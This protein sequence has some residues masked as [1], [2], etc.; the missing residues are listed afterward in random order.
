MKIAKS[1]RWQL[2]L[3]YGVLLVGVLA[4]LG[5]T[6]YKLDSGKQ[7]RQTDDKLHRYF[8]MVTQGLRQHGPPPMGGGPPFGGPP[9]D[10]FGPDGPPPSE[11]DRPEGG[12]RK[13]VIPWRV[14]ELF[15]TNQNSEGVFLMIRG[16]DG[17][18]V[19]Q[20]G[21]LPEHLDWPKLPPPALEDRPIPGAGLRTPALNMAGIYRILSDRLPTGERVLVGCSILT[22]TKE[23]QH[24]AVI[25]FL[26]G[27]AILSFGLFGGWWMVSRAIRPIAEISETAV[28][29]S[30]GD[31]SQRINVAE[32][33]S[34]LGQ[35]AA[36]LNATFERLQTVFAQQQQFTADAAHELR[37]PIAVIITQTQTA[38][39]R[40]RAAADYKATVEA[41]QRAAQRMRRL[42]E[43][44]LELARFDAGQET[45][46]RIP[47]D[48]APCI[49]ESA[50]LVAPLAG[51]RNIK[52]LPE[53]TSAQITG[54]PERIEQVLIN[55]LT[56]A[57]QYNEPGGE[58]QVTLR[59][60][61]SLAVL[62][63]TNTGPGIAPEDLAR[64]SERFYRADKS[65]SV[66]GS[67]LGLAICRAIISAHSG[68]LDIRS[69][70]G[71]GTTV[72]VRLP[73]RL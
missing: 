61:N 55:L 14:A 13:M 32:T 4:G 10:G 17:Q 43:S 62:G 41:C 73:L 68:T 36:V 72:F 47:F 30:G 21:A 27:L 26:A 6:A 44:L 57:I 50:Q 25:L 51:E 22:E 1:I 63:I 46:K 66:G 40:D 33:G 24:T 16:Q 52:I 9:P 48:L 60:E 71:R 37:T 70:P 53:L 7:F 64:V 58:V 5:V 18:I 56:N 67:G 12:P 19:A 54:N 49:E 15:D 31:L 45:L 11:D 20:L 29:I 23:L 2:Q 39:N 42:I 35:L 69:E 28:K 59:I 3:W 34:E 8:Q 65:R 38:L